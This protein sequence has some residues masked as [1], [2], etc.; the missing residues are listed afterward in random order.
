M[1]GLY[2]LGRP[3]IG[4]PTEKFLVLDEEKNSGIGISFTKAGGCI[5]E[6]QLS[7][8]DSHRFKEI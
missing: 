8:I 5:T 7:A 2:L 4:V 6:R 3:S 1:D